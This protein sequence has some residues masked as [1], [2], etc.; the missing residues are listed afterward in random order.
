MPFVP[1]FTLYDSTNTTLIYTF[2]AV[3]NT[4]LPQTPRDTVTVT[5]LRSQG[6]I[7]ID[8]GI[9]PFTANL[10]FVL[11][12]D[13]AA[14]EDLAVLID[15]L[16]VAIPINTAFVLRVDKSPSTYWSYKVKRLVPFDYSDVQQDQRL[17]RQ[18]V[19]AHFLANSW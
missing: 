18:K 12:T 14:Y 11:W 15:A 13:S 3:Q 16:E 10:D 7:V 2:M 19:S 1:K 6:A 17:A 5:N 4:N 9:K 8:G